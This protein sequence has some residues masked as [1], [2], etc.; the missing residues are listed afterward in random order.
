VSSVS[1]NS[2]FFRL[3]CAKHHFYILTPIVTKEVEDV[4]APWN[5]L[6]RTDGLQLFLSVSPP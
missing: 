1:A 5:E 3:F 2:F 6:R 4:S